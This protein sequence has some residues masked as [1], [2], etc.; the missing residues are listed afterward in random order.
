MPLLKNL[1]ETILAGLLFLLAAMA[2]IV[3]IRQLGFYWVGHIHKIVY[4]TVAAL[5][6]F[7]LYVT[8]VRSPGRLKIDAVTV[9]LTVMFVVGSLVGLLQCLTFQPGYGMRQYVAHVFS[10]F[11]AIVVYASFS[12]HNGSFDKFYQVG[13]A[14]APVIG[15]AFAV[16][17]I[18]VYA[19]FLPMGDF[20]LGFS[21]DALLVP[22][23]LFFVQR[24]YLSAL[25]V[26]ALIFLSGKRGVLLAIPPLMLLQAYFERPSRQTVIRSILVC[27]G[28]GIALVMAA[29]ALIATG[30]SPAFLNKL[31]LAVSAVFD[32]GNPSALAVASSGRTI[33]LA[34]ASAML[35]SHGAWVTGLGY[36]FGFDVPNV[37]GDYVGYQHYVHVTPFNYVL[38]HG[39][40]VSLILYALLIE[41]FISA[42]RIA[43]D[44]QD[45]AQQ[46]LILTA[47][48]YVFIS[49][50][51]FVSGSDAIYWVL[52]GL[53]G[54]I[55]SSAS[56]RVHTADAKPALQGT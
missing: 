33:E 11:A 27:A 54:G 37:A 41:R 19:V 39:W 29:A 5:A 40:I 32:L 3:L 2:A 43:R 51:A 34:K 52:L 50:T 31:M 36:G 18:V 35:S 15:I 49:L 16:A 10:G 38:Q 14:I 4:P 24:R 20:Y 42:A 1:H 6:A 53:V 12:N 9:L 13:Q 8:A 48:S 56:S 7:H 21:S 30:N 17:L 55:A 47:T 25:V 23:A 26:M 22:L 45:K 44:R 28:A 46:W